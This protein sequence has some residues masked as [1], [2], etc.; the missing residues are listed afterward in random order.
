MAGFN[1]YFSVA[2]R[3]LRLRKKPMLAERLGARWR[4]YPADWID[5]RLLIGRPFERE[6][7]A[8]AQNCIAENNLTAFYDCG[9]NIGLYS[10]LLGVKAPQL[11]QIHAFEPVPKTH[12]RLVENLR[13]NDLLGKASAHNYGLGAK[14]ETLTI[15]FNKKSSGTATLDLDEKD[16]PKRDFSDR[17]QVE[18]RIFDSQFKNAGLG[19]F[20]KLDMEGHE[21]QAL[22]GM[23]EMLANN[24]C[25]L[26]IELW[27]KNRQQA[28]DWLAGRGYHHFHNIH[29]DVYFKKA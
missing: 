27:D 4:L 23:E 19:A 1:P 5:N 9:A 28:I 18:I 17:Q 24:N 29:H 11:T 3:L 10:V 22:V 26:Q 16:N 14:A 15:A 20:M 8:F 12:A 2:K 6:Q 13:L 21:A 25:F 7:L